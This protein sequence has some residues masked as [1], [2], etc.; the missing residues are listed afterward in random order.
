MPNSMGKKLSK[1]KNEL[2]SNPE[3][4]PRWLDGRSFEPYPKEFTK[5]LKREIRRLDGEICQL[6][7][8]KQKD[9]ARIL[10][11]HHIDYNKYNCSKSNL[12]TLCRGC[13]SKVNVERGFWMRFFHEK[14]QR[15]K[16]EYPEMDNDIV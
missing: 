16:T 7:G 3:N 9:S 5:S 10:D 8:I 4:H 11:V 6:C 14:V 1:L 2:F 15:L 12:I 13:N